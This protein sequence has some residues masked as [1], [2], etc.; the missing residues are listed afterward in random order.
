M[1]L[2]VCLCVTTIILLGFKYLY[3][4]LKGYVRS[5]K[6]LNKLPTPRG[7]LP[8]IGHLLQ[9]MCSPA[10]FFRKLTETDLE[11]F[12]IYAAFIGPIVRVVILGPNEIESVVSTMKHNSKGKVYTFLSNWLGEGLLTSAGAKWQSRRKILTP[13]FHFSI[14]KEFLGIFNKETKSLVDRLLKEW[15]RPYIDIIP[16]ITNFTLLSI[17]ETSM[18]VTL[19]ANT[20]E[21]MK[22]KNAIK[23][24]GYLLF[25]R[26]R[27]PWLHSEYIHSWAPLGTKEKKIVNTLNVFTEKVIKKRE[28]NFQGIEI[29]TEDLADFSYSGRKKLALLDLLLNAKLKDGTIDSKGILDEVNTFMFE[30]HDTTAMSLVFT[31]LLLASDEKVQDKVYQEIVQVLGN[32]ASESPT[33]SHLQELHFMERCIKESLRLYPSVPFIGRELSEDVVTSK[34]IIPKGTQVDIHIYGLHRNPKVWTDPNKFDPDRFLPE[35]CIGRHPY[36]Y[37]P[38]SAGPRNCIGQKFAI[39]EMKAVLC[40]ILK[41]FRLVPIDLPEK[42][43]LFQDLV[44]R[45]LGEVKVKFILR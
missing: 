13:A 24:M 32:K 16:L 31:L 5:K 33:F 39:L 27:S 36:A 2:L 18:G 43:T 45:P 1:L 19:D 35:N 22:Y 37:L 15:Q 9:F 26:L 20:D 21:G 25:Q 4:P 30:G 6:L 8:I 42:L 38:F 41:K 3:Q 10:E 12:P 29:P 40:G 7:R 28:H 44:L 34:G 11:L 17:N 14:L 23:E